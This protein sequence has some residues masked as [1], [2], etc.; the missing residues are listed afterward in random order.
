MRSCFQ[1]ET[2]FGF[3]ALKSRDRERD[4]TATSKRQRDQLCE[5]FKN[6]KTRA[7]RWLHNA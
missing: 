5:E 3:N 7:L 2:G 1:S 4:A 6:E